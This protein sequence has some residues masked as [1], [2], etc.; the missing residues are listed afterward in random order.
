MIRDK[1]LKKCT[2][3]KFNNRQLRLS[4]YVTFYSS[5]IKMNLMRLHNRLNSTWLRRRFIRRHYIEFK[6]HC[7][8]T[9]CIACKNLVQNAQKAVPYNI[10]LHQYHLFG[11]KGAKC[12]LP[13]FHRFGKVLATLVEQRQNTILNC[14]GSFFLTTK[15]Y[16]ANTLLP[17]KHS[18]NSAGLR[19]LI[20]QIFWNRP[21]RK[22]FHSSLSEP[23]CSSNSNIELKS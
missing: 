16:L 13:S 1:I 9:L 22:K 20:S 3:S 18:V 21:K 10:F 6:S 15:M 14:P 19:E 23:L 12:P 5:R 4:L 11:G 17:L 2:Q 7:A 8:S